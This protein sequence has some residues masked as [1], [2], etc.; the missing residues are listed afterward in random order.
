MLFTGKQYSDKY[1]HDNSKSGSNYRSG[2]R[3]DLAK[4]IDP[5]VSHDPETWFQFLS[6]S[7]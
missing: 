6:V 1:P 2:T 4:P 7:A 3:R 5:P